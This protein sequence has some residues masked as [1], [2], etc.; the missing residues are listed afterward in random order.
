MVYDFSCN[1]V[2]DVLHLLNQNQLNGLCMSDYTSFGTSFG[3][4]SCSYDLITPPPNIYY[5]NISKYCKNAHTYYFDHG[6]SLPSSLVDI[7]AMINIVMI[8]PKNTPRKNN[9][10]ITPFLLY[11]FVEGINALIKRKGDLF[12]LPYAHSFI[13]TRYE[14]VSI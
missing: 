14:T 10:V 1:P 4:L 8:L 12:P 5:N 6:Y 7:I 9:V 3:C 11:Y 13:P 2:T